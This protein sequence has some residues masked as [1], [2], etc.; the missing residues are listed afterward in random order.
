MVCSS[1]RYNK[2]GDLTYRITAGEKTFPEVLEVEYDDKG[3]LLNQSLY[4]L[5]KNEDGKEF[6]KLKLR[7]EI[8]YDDE[9][10]VTKVTTPESIVMYEY[11]DTDDY[12]PEL[13]GAEITL[14]GPEFKIKNISHS[15]FLL[16]NEDG[17]DK[18]DTT[19]YI[20]E[21]SGEFNINIMTIHYDSIRILKSFK[22]GTKELLQ[23]EFYLFNGSNMVYYEQLN[24]DEDIRIR[25]TS[26][27]DSEGMVSYIFTD[28][29]EHMQTTIVKFEYPELQEMGLA[30]D[31]EELALKIYNT[32]KRVIDME[33]E[34]ELSSE[35]NVYEF[36]DRGKDDKVLSNIITTYTVDE[37]E[38]FT[39]SQYK[40]DDLGRV[41]KY[42]DNYNHYT[43]TLTYADE[44]EENPSRM[45]VKHTEPKKITQFSRDK[46]NVR[47][48]DTHL[49][50][51][52]FFEDKLITLELV[53][54]PNG[55]I[56]KIVTISS[57]DK[58][59]AQYITDNGEDATI[60]VLYDALDY[61]IGS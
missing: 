45:Y 51:Y 35:D 1:C 52:S 17:S 18:P 3:N 11:N 2:N 34:E 44:N 54:Y 58:E 32:S 40:F 9:G 22:K 21:V 7:S 36:E 57:N 46:N 59:I 19:C 41:I 6:K 29:Y 10:R 5:I 23:T 47:N 42:I 60:G 39:I 26:E 50:S 8:I 56:R 20:A 49:Y 16:K 27:F 43:N 24:A 53:K 31:D 38:Q 48:E 25:Q 12:I 4:D 13:K 14:K 37:S 55:Y 61:S 30:I 33:T 28:D 15:E